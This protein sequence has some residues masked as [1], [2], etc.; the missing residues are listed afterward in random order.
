M[1]H[2]VIRFLRIYV[3]TKRLSLYK[4]LNLSKDFL[5]FIYHIINNKGVLDTLRFR[6]KFDSFVYASLLV[7]Q[8]L[9][10]ASIA[11]SFIRLLKI[12]SC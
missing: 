6:K 10:V 3:E 5:G 8:S 2:Q 7:V 9:F 11:L 4:A 1:N 12:S